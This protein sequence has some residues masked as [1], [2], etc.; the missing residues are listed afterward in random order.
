MKLFR[1]QEQSIEFFRGQ[2]AVF[3]A[4]DPG[5]GKTRVAI[6]LFR[7]RIKSDGRA[8]I[9]CA[10][11]SL[12]RS[13]WQND[14][15]KFAP[16]LITSIAY[17]HNREKAFDQPADVYIINHDGVNWLAKQKPA[18]FKRFSTLV[19]DESGAFKHHT[20]QR[21]KAIAKIRK[22]FAF[23]HLMNGTPAT[24]TILDIWH[25]MFLLDGG[26]RL[27]KSFF[28]FRAAV[29]SP[30]QVGP[31]ATMVR[32][33]DRPGVEATVAALVQDITMRH[34]FR[35]CIDIPPNHQYVV[36]FHLAPEHMK[37]YKT[38]Q[39]LELLPLKEAV[40]DPVNAA[41][42]Y[43]KLMQI[44]SGAVYESDEVYHL[45]N[46]DRY[47][48]IMD[49]LAERPHSIVFFLW[50]HQ[51]QELIRAAEA[52]GYT[53]CLLDG[54][55]PDTQRPVIVDQF[56]AGYYKVMFAHPK[57]AAHGLTLVKATT[58]IWA[59]PTYNLEWFT[60]GNKRIDRAGQTQKTETII[61]VGQGTVD[62]IV[63]AAL[64]N[65]GVRMDLLLEQLKEAA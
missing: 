19:V 40:I 65:K 14:I 42:V 20:A 7:A 31:Q 34:Y 12:L 17:A 18:F 55:V 64:E 51:K 35:D 28:Q 32:W 50:K 2:P 36:P 13:A 5:T 11:K 46:T 43:T 15:R 21:S 3:D 27:G 41:A 60:Q 54:T 47:E 33:I 24:N 37:Q 48:L 38:M 45:L 10:P 1:H 25:Q 9:V 6:E 62:E 26:A 49:L 58:T 16:E 44:A 29:C 56:E 23:V 22:F 39:Q 59:S 53:Y 4:S 57:S 8:I 30:Q 52:R 63:M 61:V